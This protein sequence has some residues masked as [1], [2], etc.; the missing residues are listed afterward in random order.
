MRINL[1]GILISIF[2]VFI[3]LMS[4]CVPRVRLFTLEVISEPDTI[5]IVLLDEIEQ[6][7]FEPSDIRLTPF[8]ISLKPEERVVVRVVDEEPLQELEEIHV[9]YG[10]S[11][12]SQDN[13]RVITIDSNKKLEAK[14]LTKFK[15]T[16]ST[17]PKK[18]VGI[19]GSGWYE[20]GSSLT[21][22]APQVENYTFNGWNVNGETINDNPLVITVNK[23]TKIEAVYS[24]IPFRTLSVGSEPEGLKIIID[25]LEY[26]SPWSIQAREGTSHTIEFKA[27]ERDESSFV[28]GIDTKYTFK[29]WNDSIT[30]NPRTVLLDSDKSFTVQTET[31]YLVETSTLPEGV[32]SIDGAGWKVKD[33]LF[34]YVSPDSIGY[35]FS[36]WEVNGIRI[37]GRSI[38]IIHDSPKKIVAVYT[39]KG[40]SVNVDTEPSGL[41]VKVNGVKKVAPASVV[42]NHG[43]TV[44]L[45]I[46]TPQER[47]ESGNVEGIDTKYSFTRWNDG[48]TS[49]TR[50]LVLSSSVSYTAQMKS[51][52]FV[53]VSSS[54]VSI[55]GSGWYEKG[56]NLTLTA[57]QV[58][59]YSFLNWTVNGEIV[60]N[61]ELCITVG[62]PSKI[63]AV[64]SEIPFRTL[65]VGSEPEGLKI[66]ID[67]LE[68]TSP[69]SI[70]AREG[71]SHTI[72]FKAQERDE[73]SFVS[74]IDTKYTFKSWN[75]SIT[76]NPR[77]V[78]LDSD[79]SF[80]VQ[81]ETQYLVETS[82]LPEGVASIDGAGWKVKDSL[83]SYVSPDSI[84]Y[85]FSH[86]E[87]NGIKIDG[88]SVE[89]THDSPKKIV[90]VYALKGYSVNVDT[91]PSGL[92]VKVNGVKKVAPAS[93]VVN[94]G[95]T[96]SVEIVTPQERDESVNVEG[97]DTRYSFTRWSDGSTAK[98]R[99]ITATGNLS[100][101]AQMK[102]EYLVSVSSAV[103][104]IP[105]SGW[106]EKGS[107]LTLTAPQVENYTFNGWNVNGE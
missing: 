31:R 64:Y 82:T 14:T 6:T 88:R 83:F 48:N 97:T 106:Y 25:S 40:Y 74:G 99:T 65:S 28:S 32:A 58:E 70:Q 93:V 15:V 5:G 101:T 16:V 44:S 8:S 61:Q 62:E 76:S 71:T 68:Y 39:L 55:P 67:S 47:D 73:S 19:P 49:T 57:P 27:Q 11:D 43:D 100:L 17:D 53:S 26:T 94:H 102:S 60:E 84:G 78:L 10:W 3:V 7:E 42:V 24:E 66:I 35:D 59:G 20:K 30:S 33:S 72:E 38:E 41:E 105:G 69:W 50:N 77:T 23:P 87:V 36:H 4:S 98:A 1:K 46:L 9:F 80:T 95:D 63:E 34:S 56:S 22:T 92:E 37:D 89:I 90:A 79:K 103:A 86:W 51:E 85:D 13:P 107:S 29:S 104:S 81:T 91:E 2:I 18:L 45:E 52:Y 96:V 21:L 75:D 54:V 12:G